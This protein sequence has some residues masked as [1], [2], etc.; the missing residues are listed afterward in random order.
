MFEILKHQKNFSK[1]KK[2]KNIS[3]VALLTTSKK[4]LTFEI[5]KSQKNFSKNKTF[6]LLAG[7][8]NGFSFG[9]DE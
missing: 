8:D 1:N 9:F 5:L 3:D 7:Y 4:I 2:L 6:P